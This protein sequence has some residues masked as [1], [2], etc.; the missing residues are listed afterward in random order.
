MDLLIKLFNIDCFLIFN[1]I[2]EQK[3]LFFECE[4]SFSIVS[5]I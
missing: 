2:S 5:F 3:N 4:W 1:L